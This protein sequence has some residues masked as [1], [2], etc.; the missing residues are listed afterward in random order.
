MPRD[1]SIALFNL[2]KSLSKNEKRYY[3]I[4]AQRGGYE[5]T[6]VTKFFDA[7]SN[8]EKYNEDKILSE[9]PD[10]NPQQLSNMKAELYKHI[11]E[12]LRLYHDGKIIDINIR[13][14]I[15]FAQLL[16]DRSLYNQA[17]SQL[18]KAKKAAT[19]HD[20]L[21][22]L[23]EISRLEKRILSYII[24][25]ENQKRVNAIVAEVTSLNEKINRVNLL[26]NLE[27]KLNSLYKKVGFIRDKRDHR[28]IEAYLNKN[29]PEYNETVLSDLEKI[30]LYNL[31][32]GY[33]FFIQD[34]QSGYNEA[35]KLY[36]LFTSNPS[37]I[38]SK[39]DF[40]IQALNKL[41]IAQSKLSKY[42]EF[43]E[44]V[45]KIQDIPKIPGIVLNEDINTKLYKYYYLHELNRYMLLG[46][47]QSGVNMI[48]GM[49]GELYSFI[50]SVD[51]HTTIIFY[52]KIACIY[53][54]NSDYH[55]TI[56]WLNKI[57]GLTQVDIR[58]DIHCF[59]RIL[60][61][62]AHYELENMDVIDY[63]IRSTYRFLAKKYDLR[64]YQQY[65]LRFLKGLNNTKIDEDISHKFKDLRTQL[66]TLRD[67][68]YE[69][70]A[71]IYF[72][73]ISWLESKIE[74]KK[75]GEII[76]DKA[77]KRINE[78]NKITIN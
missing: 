49:K 15:D 7:L 21:E 73:I 55:Q 46:D 58:R 14:H 63:Y 48:Q 20:N 47:F 17:Y 72:D 32:I 4:Y 26:S 13:K 37:L 68:P 70:R 69:K 9:N 16:I 8:Q 34:F 66:L 61:L 50:E 22:L 59:A 30:H 39:T 64:M 29:M 19:K 31:F 24:D 45:N 76:H 38:L 41:S 36:E 43:I 28:A 12:S 25:N 23:L 77:I 56:I 3:K 60:N 18:K 27:S 51:P 62:V 33:F 42:N 6:K 5:D 65:I 10:F 74:S 78:Q 40:Y 44:T 75:V 67:K 71:F 53:F 54:G 2:V 35:K 11:L 57:I 52:Y 1:K